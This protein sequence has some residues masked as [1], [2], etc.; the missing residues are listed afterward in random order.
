MANAPL[1]DECAHL[2]ILFAIE[3]SSNR[4][5]LGVFWNQWNARLQSTPPRSLICIPD[6]T[7]LE[8]FGAQEKQ[9]ETKTS[10]PRS[11]EFMA[12]QY[13]VAWFSLFFGYGFDFRSRLLAYIEISACESKS[14]LVRTL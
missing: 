11:N 13:H 4:S 3:C 8:Y 10:K 14:L 9:T 5:A 6:D 7:A 2:I 12:K 1:I